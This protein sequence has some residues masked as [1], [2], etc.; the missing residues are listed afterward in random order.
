MVQAIDFAVRDSAGGLVRG[1]VGGETGSNF[2]Q[3][4]SG[5]EISLNLSRSSIVAYERA[6]GDL[7]ITLTDGSTMKLAGFFA[8]AVENELYLSTNGEIIAVDLQGGQGTLFASYGATDSWDKYSVLDDLRFVD[9]D[10]FA[11]AVAVS[12][13]PAG[14]GLFVPGLLGGGLGAGGIGAGLIGGGV[15]LGGGGGGGGGGG[16]PLPTVDDPNRTE[17]ITSNTV[18]RDRDITGTGIAGDTVVVTIGTQT[19][20]TT[21]RPDGTWGVTFPGTDLPPDGNYDADVVVTPPGATPILL[22]GPNYIIDVTAPPVILTQGFESNGDVENLAEH[23][24]GVTLSGTSEAGATINVLVNGVTK[25]V[26]VGQSGTWSVNYSTTELPG[27]E[28]TEDAVIR[29]TDPLGNVTTVNDRVVID[30][31]PN[32]ITFDSVTVDNTVN[33]TENTGGFT[34]SGM[35]TANSTISMT[36]QGVTRTVTVGDDGKWSLVWAAGVLTP[37]EYDATITATSTDAAGNIKTATHTM[38][39]DT[40]TS[41]AFTGN[42]ETDNT[43][44]ATERG[45]GVTLTGTAQP[46]ATV[47]VAWNGTTVQATVGTNG[48]WTANFAGNSLPTSMLP[49]ATTAVVTATDAAG[50]TATASRVITVD[51]GTDVTIGTSQFGGDNIESKGEAANGIV[52][53]GTAE[54]GASVAVNFDGITRTVTA[55]ANGN[56]TASWSASE[57]RNGQYDVT[58]NVTAT[59]LAGNVDTASHLVRIDTVVQPF[60]S[61]TVPTG[62]DAIVNKVEADAGLTVTG[63]VEAGSTV[64]VRLADGSSIAATVSGTTWSAIIPAGQIPVGESTVPMTATATDAV[65][66]TSVLTQQVQIDTIVRNFART[67]G[68]ISGDGVLNALEVAAGLTLQGTV[69]PNSSVVVR[70]ASGASRTLQ[71]GANGLWSATFAAGDLP[72]GETTTTATITATDRAGNTA[73]ITE[74]FAVD[75]VAPGAPDVITFDRDFRTASSGVRGVG[76]TSSDDDLTFFKVA[77]SGTA[78]AMA[79]TESNNPDNPGETTYSFGSNRVPDGTYLVINTEDTAGNESSTLFIVNNTSSSTVDLTR[80]GLEGFDFSTINLSVAPQASLTITEAQIRSLTGA[81]K[82]LTIAGGADDSVT[83][84]GAV[85]TGNNVTIDGQTYSIYTLGNQGATVH[86]DDDIQRFI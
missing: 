59:D 69:E 61:N 86:L 30:T 76:V 58:V 84:T 64:V 75:T 19:Q 4:G 22:D 7:L 50:N 66:N 9:G 28:Y 51:T 70:L 32:T 71:V 12:D 56:W 44:N 49:L 10:N 6:G 15:L 35:G 60:T 24:S 34:I 78:T 25:T 53:T 81:D 67:G 46:G 72:T 29:A 37:G 20:T 18:D 26:T 2:I 38:R 27:G 57:V 63:T 83:M 1:A 74:T 43:V 52:L 39:V 23:A 16:R 80:T 33:R 41:V 21:I 82:T 17:T 13:E 85:D 40:Q 62:A 3:M 36:L 54:A 5:E 31:I 65:G 77:A 79:A 55:D 42:V 68:T 11:Q 45:D 47:S 48:S 73:V 14:Q 8:G